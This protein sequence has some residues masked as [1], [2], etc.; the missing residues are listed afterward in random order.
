MDGVRNGWIDS[1][2]GALVIDGWNNGCW[3]EQFCFVIA[4]LS[5]LWIQES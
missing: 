2:V 1:S 5:C 3:F 4:L